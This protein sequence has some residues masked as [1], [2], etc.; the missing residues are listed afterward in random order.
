MKKL[1]FCVVPFVLLAACSDDSGNNEYQEKCDPETYN[2]RCVDGEAI[3]C[4]SDGSVYKGSYYC[5]TTDELMKG[6]EYNGELTGL[7]GLL[8]ITNISFPVKNDDHV[9]YN[10]SCSDNVTESVYCLLP[11]LIVKRTCTPMPDGKSYWRYSV[12]ECDTICLDEHYGF[13]HIASC[14][15]HG[16]S[17]ENEGPIGCNR[18]RA[19]YCRDKKVAEEICNKGEMCISDPLNTSC[20]P[21]CEEG[22]QKIKYCLY[23]DSHITGTCA[24]SPWNNG[25]NYPIAAPL[26]NYYGLEMAPE[27]LCVNGN[28]IFY[29]T[30]P[31]DYFGN[32]N[33][34]SCASEN[35][36]NKGKC[37]SNTAVYC[38]YPKGYHVT[39]QCR[40]VWS[41]E[42][43]FH[44]GERCMM[45]DSI[46]YCAKPCFT[47]GDKIH[48]LDDSGESTG[49][50]ICE[51]TPNGLYYVLQ[52]MY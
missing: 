25:K 29:S 5:Q 42:H 7:D 41:G 39:Q 31:T 20:R 1:L 13:N 45:K 35:D 32:P 16:D 38:K 19:Y 40:T 6:I 24:P 12:D 48:K 27:G 17:C 22:G 2:M 36:N 49:V 33:E 52:E 51:Q 21:P 43:A 34:L 15:H 10:R 23:T 26:E 46:P 47:L 30:E 9:I 50:F 28:Y 4:G 18:D 8:E 44:N 14:V 3:W 11:H 37:L